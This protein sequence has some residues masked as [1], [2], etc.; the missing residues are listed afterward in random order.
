VSAG[1]PSGEADLRRCLRD[2]FGLL[3]L[4]AVWRARPPG[5]ILASFAEALETTVAAEV[6]AVLARSGGETLEVVRVH[7]ADA[8]PRLPDARRWFAPLASSTT[9]TV[10]RAECGDLGVLT[11]VY[12]PI[13]YNAA[14]GYVVVASAR[15]RFPSASDAAVI[16]AATALATTSVETARAL[17]D[18][19]AALRAKDEFLAVLGHEL[20][21]PLAPIVTALEII[22]AKKGGNLSR[23]EEIVKKQVQHLARLVDD[24]LDVTRITR[25]TMELQKSLVE[26]AA[27][28]DEAVASTEAVFA[29]RGHALRVNVPREG[30]T[31]CADGFRLGQVLVNLLTNAA[32]YSPDGGT[33]EITA[34]ASDGK[35]I[36]SVLDSG[37]GIPSS[38]LPDI[39]E[40]FVQGRSQGDAQYGGLGIGLA[41]VRTLVALHGGTVTASSP[42]DGAGSRF[43]VELPLATAGDRESVEPAPPAAPR[44]KRAGV[45]VLVVDDNVDAGE[46]L[47]EALGMAGYAVR[48][49]SEPTEALAAVQELAPDVVVLDIGM[50]VLD[51]YAVADAIRRALGRAAPALVAVTGYGQPSDRL[52][53]EAAGFAAHFVKPVDVAKLAAW[54]GEHTAQVGEP[55]RVRGPA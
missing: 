17:L 16:R 53:T 47:A 44:A 41:L 48:S 2:V 50:P 14:Q 28:V 32:K 21:N 7:G 23:E 42:G 45:R 13:G 1:A 24:L 27:V 38:L 26:L 46:L 37:I 29:K 6:I 49:L 34:R 43:D 33:I 15:P 4:P 12:E 35:A 30:L 40:P 39:F 52:K 25:G 11:A 18:R 8:K 10:A 31:L 5:E 3:A 54:I 55:A 51:G 19:E 20:R 36:L 9:S 22:G